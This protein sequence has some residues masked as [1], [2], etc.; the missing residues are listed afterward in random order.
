MRFAG[1]M[2]QIR[3]ANK[4]GRM[5]H[6]P[7]LAMFGC[8]SQNDQA[9]GAGSPRAVALGFIGGSDGGPSRPQ[10]KRST[11][12][13]LGWWVSFGS[14]AMKPR[15]EEERRTALANP[16]RLGGTV[17]CQSR[18]GI[19]IGRGGPPLERGLEHLP[20]PIGQQS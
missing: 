15:S 13:D 19:E 2:G 3:S 5:E 17:L 11:P 9:G 8:H 18:C 20:G 10:K 1:L 16:K 7:L 14:A 6:I 12:P 4:V